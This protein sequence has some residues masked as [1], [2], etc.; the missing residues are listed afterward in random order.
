[1]NTFVNHRHRHDHIG[2]KPFTTGRGLPV[3]TYPYG[4]PIAE[5]AN[6]FG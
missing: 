3:Q 1:M 6:L 5:R 4:H 2:R